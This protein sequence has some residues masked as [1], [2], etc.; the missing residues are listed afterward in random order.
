MSDEDSV[1]DV[2]GEFNDTVNMSPGEL[3]AWEESEN[4]AVYVDRKS[5]G[6]PAD[7]PLDDVRRLL[8]TPKDEWADEDDGFNEVTEANEV[9][10]FVGRMSEAEQGEP[11]PGTDP[12]LSKRDASLL[13]WGRDPNPKSR[14]FVGDRQR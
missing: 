3:D 13:S 8:E 4:R 1:D 11:M 2:F 7:E 6:Q 14:D 10:A 5:G 9:L 12:E